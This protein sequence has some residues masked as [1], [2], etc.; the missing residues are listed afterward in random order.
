MDLNNCPRRLQIALVVFVLMA[1]AM[2]I[3]L[4]ANAFVPIAPLTEHEVYAN[5]FNTTLGFHRVFVTYQANNKNAKS[6]HVSCRHNLAEVARMLDID[7]EYVQSTT[8]VQAK[9]LKLQKGYMADVE[10]IAELDTHRKIYEMMEKTDTGSALILSCNI[11]VEV[12]LKS[13]LAA[14]LGNGV[15]NN[16]DILYIGRTHS[17]PSEPMV[18][19]LKETMSQLD[20][21]TSLSELEQVKLQRMWTKKEFLHRTTQSYRSTYPKGTHAYAVN[22]RMARRLNRRLSKRMTKDPHELD[23]ILAD[24]AIVGLSLAYSVSPPPIAIYSP[25][26]SDNSNNR[27][28]LRRSVL[29][30]ASLRKDNP[31]EYAPYKDV[32]N[33]WSL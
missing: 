25:E 27:Q 13:R 14:A 32:E 9:Q 10:S 19:E 23:Y 20:V 26:Q 17:E 15:A 33:M 22:G 5:A 29:Q 31:S 2:L 8:L 4:Y 21:V 7:I 28:Y 24:V 30:S 6:A 12:D 18:D 3:D 16:Y 1:A 11:D